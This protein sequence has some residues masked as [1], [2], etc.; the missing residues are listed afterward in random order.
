MRDARRQNAE[1]VV[2]VTNTVPLGRWEEH[3]LFTM[4]LRVRQRC[5][6]RA[7]NPAC[8]YTST[9]QL[10]YV[11]AVQQTCGDGCPVAAGQ[12]PI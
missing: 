7:S 4:Q 6:K 2:V 1:Y 5:L 11:L 8:P 12:H 10:Y 3:T 9:S